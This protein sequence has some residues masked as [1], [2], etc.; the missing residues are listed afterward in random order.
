MKAS[1][2]VL[3]VDDTLE[4][5]RVL[6]EMLE[7]DGHEVRIASAGAQA[8]DV[9]RIAPPDLILLDVMMPGMDGHQVCR[10]LKA[11]PSTAE[12]P[13]IFLT[14]LNDEADEA[15]GLDLGAVDYITKPFKMDLVRKRI[16]NHLAL[17]QLQR[18]L[19]ESNSRLEDLVAERTR[20]L[21]EAN[22]RL[23]ALDQAKTQFLRLLS[24]E[25]QAPAIGLVG[26]GQLALKAIDDPAKRQ[27]LQDLFE[28]NRNRLDTILAQYHRLVELQETEPTKLPPVRLEEVLRKAWLAAS[29]SG[30]PL[31]PPAARSFIVAADETLLTEALVP[32][33][34]FVHEGTDA[35]SPESVLEEQG[36]RIQLR[37]RVPLLRAPAREL[38]ERHLL[39]TVLLEALGG[40]VQWGRADDVW[41][42]LLEFPSYQP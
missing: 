18:E 20:D 27:R 17:R 16:H 25:V 39:P 13:V 3:I 14:A 31:P 11:D 8:L 33:I 6:G 4:N 21:T 10:L 22:R 36:K 24:Q 35:E 37:L 26:I 34:R 5:L 15:L 19:Q 42:L 28:S 38:R 12:I 1:H 30:A 2:T 32:L 9:A 29:P 23:T 40:T 41:E 7:L